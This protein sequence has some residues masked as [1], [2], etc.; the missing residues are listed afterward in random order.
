MT[1]NPYEPPKAEVGDITRQDPSP[2]L[3]NPNAAANWSLLFS[4]AFGAFLHM[5]NWQALG[6]PD[7]ARSAKTWFVLTLV[8]F[9]GFAVALVVTPS[10]NRYV[11]SVR[12]VGFLLLLCWYFGSGRGQAAY[13]KEHC[14]NI[15]PKRG[16]FKPLTVALIAL[17]AYIALFT[18]VAAVLKRAT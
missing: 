18:I 15:Y 8:L 17:F 7:K 6:H 10:L 2:P 14:G 12:L 4:A 3:W 1:P 11:G 9:G 16:W 5:K 13:V